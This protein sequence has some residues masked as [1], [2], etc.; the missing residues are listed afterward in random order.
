V[1]ETLERELKLEAGDLAFRLPALPGAPL[2]RRIFESVYYDTASRSL[3]RAGITL[4]RRL[5]NGRNLWQLKLPRG[6][7]RAE[8]EVPGGPAA[9]PD[10]LRRLLVAHVRRGPLAPVAT[11]RTRREGMRVSE[12]GR[13]IADVVV[14]SV[15]VM[16]ALR[17]ERSFVEIEIEL[18]D[19]G[20]REL[21]RLGKELR[22]AGAERGPELPKVLRVLGIPRA[23]PPAKSAPAGEHLR[24]LLGRQL[25]ELL[26]H[27]PGT[28][29]GTDPEDL[30]KLRVA[31]RRGR[32]LLRAGAEL[33]DPSRA[34]P[35]RAELGW[36]GSSLGAV[37][38]LDVMIEHLRGVLEQLPDRA[39]AAPVVAELEAER[40]TARAELLAALDGDRYVVLLDRL[41]ELVCSSPPTGGP[42]LREIAAG[43]YRKAR[44]AAK[45]FDG[46]PSDDELHALRIK[47]KR[48]RYASEL[49]EQSMGKPAASVVEAAKALQDVI[50]EHQDSVVAEE[51]IRSIAAR[52]ADPDVSFGAGVLV[53][54]ER[55]RRADA[56]AEAP[57]AWEELDALARK[58]FA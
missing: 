12:D 28:R 51:R 26:A 9:P 42:S 22:R 50:G 23:E 29:L 15:D 40:E 56:R 55:P 35:V 58:A 11:L 48:L 33:V 37:R 31:T 54:R 13:E 19:G 14:D 10:E 47:A 30:H 6:A 57:K 21:R 2:E 20:A 43:E 8:L 16:D 18:V 7:H 53:E 4:R 17:V 36:L 27:D 39:Q 1:R 24:Y 32:A 44:K 34:E 25:R 49:A 41:E 38:D 5:E 52:L 46:T 3:A 45:I